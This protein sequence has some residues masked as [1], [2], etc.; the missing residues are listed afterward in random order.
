M[1][2][3]VVSQLDAAGLYV[4]E[5][6]TTTSPLDPDVWLMPAGCVDVAP[7]DIPEGQQARLVNGVFVLEP[8]P[9]P[10][11]PEVYVPTQAELITATRRKAADLRLPI[12]SIL[13]DMQIDALV[14]GNT[15]LA[16]TIKT[17]KAGLAAVVNMNLSGFQTAEEMEY[18]VLAS[19]QQ[20]AATAPASLRA[21]FKSLVP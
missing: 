17:L 3:K 6:E 11:V 15:S 20:L 18:A 19:Y 14:D 5:C 4:G 10:E 21:A 13:S 16:T 12:A 8:V 7:P 1:R 2:K 9:V